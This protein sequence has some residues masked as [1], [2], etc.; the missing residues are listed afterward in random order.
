MAPVAE[1][2]GQSMAQL[3]LA[4]VLRDPRVSTAVVGARTVP[5]FDALL[6]FGRA[7][8]LDADDLEALDP[9]VSPAATPS[10]V[11]AEPSGVPW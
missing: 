4:W 3:A 11:S 1:R 5:Q 6:D 2:R 8:A 9:P 7:G 10:G